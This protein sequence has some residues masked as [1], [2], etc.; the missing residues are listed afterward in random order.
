MVTYKD[1]HFVRQKTTNLINKQHR[2]LIICMAMRGA[3]EY[4]KLFEV[5]HDINIVKAEVYVKDFEK[6]KLV[7]RLLGQNVENMDDYGSLKIPD[8]VV[9]EDRRIVS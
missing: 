5:F 7:S 4:D 1:F 9:A 2:T 8:L 3:V 6:C